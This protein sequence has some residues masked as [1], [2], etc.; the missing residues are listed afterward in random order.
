MGYKYPYIPDKRM[1]AAVM[2]ACKYIRDTGYF[3]KAIRYYADK[4]DV[5]AEE[6]ASHIRA[7]QSSGQRGKSPSTKGRKYKWFMVVETVFSDAQWEYAI[8]DPMIIK[9]ISAESVI[10]R[11][12]KSDIRRTNRDDYGGSYAP[13]YGHHVIAE[14]DNEQTAMNELENYEQYA[15]AIFKDRFR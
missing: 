15:K 13:V 7:R 2:G 12:I 1:Y 6:L 8:N 4:Y 5:D 9:G 10:K 3:N 14:F 11:F